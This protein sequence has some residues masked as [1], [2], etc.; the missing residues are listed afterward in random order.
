VAA[1]NALVAVR[2]GEAYYYSSKHAGFQGVDSIGKGTLGA[3]GSLDFTD[4]YAANF[5]QCFYRS[6]G[7]P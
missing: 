5:P 4:T 7:N 2:S 1:R 6:Q 3:S